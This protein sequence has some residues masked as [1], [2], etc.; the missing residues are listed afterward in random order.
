MAPAISRLLVAFGL[1]FLNQFLPEIPGKFNDRPIMT[2]Y[3][4]FEI[5]NDHKIFY[6]DGTWSAEGLVAQN[7][8]LTEG[9][10]YANYHINTSPYN[11]LTTSL[12]QPEYWCVRELCTGTL[13][14]DSFGPWGKLLS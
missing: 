11:T 5:Q 2:V 4:A 1:D 9:Y 7:P 13:V 10:R 12:Q 6:N 14:G 3:S 8:R